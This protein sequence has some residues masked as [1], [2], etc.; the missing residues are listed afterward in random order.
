MKSFFLL[1]FTFLYILSNAQSLTYEWANV[2][3]G[4]DYD[5]IEGLYVE[6]NGNIY[7]TGEFQSTIDFDPSAQ[8]Y[9]LT[10]NVSNDIF[11]AKYTSSGD[12]I[13]A[14]QLSGTSNEESVY[15]SGDISG[16]IYITGTYEGTLD[17]DPATGISEHTSNGGEDLFL[18]KYDCNGNF[19]WANSFGNSA[20]QRSSKLIIDDNDNVIFTGFFVGTIDFDPGSGIEELTS[21]DVGMGGSD[22]FLAKYDSNGD[23]IWVNSYADITNEQSFD[24]CLDNSG[25]IIMTG[26]WCDNLFTKQFFIYR[27]DSNGS[28]V[29]GFM[30]PCDIESVGYSIT[31]DVSNNFY[32]T[33]IYQGTIDFD[34]STNVSELTSQGYKDVFIAKYNTNFSFVWA[35]SIGGTST[36]EPV[37]INLSSDNTIQVAGNFKDIVD[38]DPGSGT[39]FFTSLGETDIFILNL[40]TAGNYISKNI[41]GDLS[42]DV[43]DRMYFNN[44]NMIIAG[45]FDGTVDFD[46][47]SNIEN[48]SSIGN[49]DIFIAKY[50]TPVGIN[51]ISESNDLIIYPN[52]TTGKFTIDI[53][54]FDKI[55]ILNT[56]GQVV[57]ETK[58]QN[59]DIRNLSDGIYLVKV[60]L[61]NETISEKI[62]KN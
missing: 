57:I 49:D 60:S 28:P 44:G 39:D 4:Y 18:A 61:G 62:I 9:E 21:I 12:F 45:S 35:K 24:L 27:I 13:W 8:N 23:F 55:E 46:P 17:F 5:N 56:L 1:A 59:I 48:L 40:D 6:N 50:N 41:I 7:I 31:T 15:I 22:I 26:Y 52:P 19:L 20:L 11:I 53:S 38:F 16:N 30:I 54:V 2:L 10:S 3:F 34:L 36:D 14:K 33:G 43:I 25:N 42:Y 58:K 29:D 32:V 47:G 37:N 51:F